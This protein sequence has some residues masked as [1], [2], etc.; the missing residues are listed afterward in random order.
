MIL[1][2][3]NPGGFVLIFTFIHIHIHFI[4][5]IGDIEMERVIQILLLEKRIANS[6]IAQ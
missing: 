1:M 5:W 4:V 3:Q 6:L 2:H